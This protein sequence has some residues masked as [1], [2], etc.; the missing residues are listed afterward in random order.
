MM[1]F[2]VFCRELKLDDREAESVFPGFAESARSFTAETQL[3]LTDAYLDRVLPWVDL[4]DADNAALRG[5]AA[6]VRSVPA[7]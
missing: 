4:P 3:E 6:R 7:A 5:F 2:G 1:D